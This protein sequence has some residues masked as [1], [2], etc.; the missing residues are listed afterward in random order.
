VKILKALLI[1]WLMTIAGLWAYGQQT[2]EVT[3]TVTDATGALVAEATVTA[4]NTATQQVRSAASNDTGTYTLPYLQPGVYELRAEKTGFKLITHP[5]VN[6]QVGDIARIDFTME[7]GMVSQNVVVNTGEPLLTTESVSLGTVVGSKQITGLPLNGRDYLSLVALTPNVVSEAPST[8]SSGLQGGVR[9]ATAIAIAGQRL[10]FNHYTLDGVENTDPN[11]NSYIIHPSI[12]A[13]QEFRVQTGVYS[14]EFGKGA[15]QINATTRSGTNEFHLVA[16]EFLRNDY[17]DAKEW[18]QV[19]KKDPFR[20]NDYGFTLGGPLAIPKLFDAKDKLFFMSNFETLHDRLTTQQVGSTA[21]LAMRSGDFSASGLPN[22]Y[23]PSTRVFTGASTGTATQF[24]GN[25]IP[26]SRLSPQAIALLNY[27][28]LPTT[29][30]SNLSGNYV[31]QA[32]QPT[33][34][35]QFNQRIDWIENTK[36]SWFGRFSWES[37]LSSPAVLFEQANTANTNTTVRQAVLGNTYI[38][39]PSMVNEARFAWAQFNND[40]A[41]YFANKQNVQSMLGIDGLV[42]PSAA[43]YG[44]PAI[45]L[46]NGLNS[47]GGITPWVTRDD[48]FQWTDSLSMIKGAHSIKVGGTIG[49]DRYNQKGNQKS[50]GEFDFDG[51]STNNPGNPNKTGYLFADFM[52]GQP[53][54][55]Y[56]V[57]SLA[58]AQLRRTNYAV[59]IQDD[60][61]VTPRLTVNLGLR[62]ENIRPWVDKYNQQINADVFTPGVTTVPAPRFNTPVS[63]IIPNSPSPILTRP[64]RGDF[65]QGIGFR[66]ATGQPVQRGNQYMGKALVN[67]NNLNF[68]PRVG[69]NYTLGT[70]WSIRAGFGIFY[71]TDIGNAVFDMSRNLGGKDGAVVASNARTVNLSAPWAGEQ[72]SASCPGYSGPC[73]A[74]P[75]INSNFQNNRTPYIEQWIANVQRQITQNIV[76]EVGYLG[77]QGHHLDRDFIVNQ[78]VPKAGPTDNS[79]TTSR[80]P[81]PKFGPIQQAA[82]FDNANYNAGTIKLSQRLSHGLLYVVAYTWSKSL[83]GG[84]ALRNN[85][86]DTLWPTNSYNLRA[87]RGLS[88]FD[89]P[90]RFV[91]SY[92]YDLPF[93]PG[94]RFVTGGFLSQIIGGW[95][96]GGILT[97][98]DGTPYNVAQLGDTAGLG[99]LGNQPDYGG[100]SP[101]P[102]NRT[103]NHFWNPAGFN[104]TNPDLSWRPGNESRNTLFTPGS[105]DFDASLSKDIHIWESHS[106]NFRFETFNTLNHPNWRVPANDPRNLATFGV[107]TSANAMRQL[108]FA[109][110]YSF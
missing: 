57:T 78:A 40:Y 19:G 28:P 45:G 2:G 61:K 49:R 7:V 50:E 102:S 63:T 98:A 105:Q 44:V 8:G 31:R 32:L 92:L 24:S 52:L 12:D 56:R 108:Q 94:R 80:R 1:T 58:N 26:Q 39:S 65:Y 33:D 17:F 53:S 97:L 14:A 9:S 25:V 74:G 75:Q 81:F 68:G 48:L 64:G 85:T 77:N 34:E 62:Y 5:G 13:I 42:A 104:Y 6:V 107:I 11:F 54:Q 66:Y 84:S 87:E 100:V 88:Q 30:G 59:F 91:A 23:D 67:P 89:L 90:R 93:G 41:G 37:D 73:I 10:E 96:F 47:F 72:G 79:S 110:K 95:Q 35:T 109:L 46:G 106:L 18:R 71:A 70:K 4:T 16:F 101:V 103:V 99:T 55:Y 60:W 27:Y 22:I 38:I 86:G 69:I 36:S 82:S 15:S 21:T 76:V 29:P 43:A 83:D 51:Q 3:G 20:R